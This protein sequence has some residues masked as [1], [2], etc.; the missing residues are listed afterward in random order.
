MEL[1]PFIKELVC[2]ITFSGD[3]DGDTIIAV[4]ERPWKSPATAGMLTAFERSADVTAIWSW[5]NAT[6]VDQF[7]VGA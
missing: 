7:T 1:S 2:A 3:V 5:R 6:G 4:T